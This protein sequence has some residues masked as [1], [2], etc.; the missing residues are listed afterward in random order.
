[1]VGG[2]LCRQQSGTFGHVFA[3]TRAHAGSIWSRIIFRLER[4]WRVEA[5]NAFRSLPELAE[6]RA[7]DLGIIAGRLQRCCGR[8]VALPLGS[9]HLYIRSGPPLQNP[10][11]PVIQQR[12]IV[13]LNQLPRLA[14]TDRHD[15]VA[16]TTG[17]QAYLNS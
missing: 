13:A 8:H 12:I 9:S 6:L 11:G 3:T 2:L 5:I 1:V 14:L 15:V 4:R 10:T 7:E 17:W 16:L